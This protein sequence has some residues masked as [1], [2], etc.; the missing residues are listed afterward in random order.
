MPETH[1]IRV[2]CVGSEN[3]MTHLLHVMLDNA[4]MLDDSEDTPSTRESYEAQVHELAKSEGGCEDGFLYECITKSA[5]GTAMT[6]TTMLT[7]RRESCGLWTACF[8]YESI[9]NF[10]VEDWLR[11]HQRCNR[12]LMAAQYASYSFGLE[13]GSVLLCGGRAMDSWDTMAEVWL[14]LIAKYECGYPPEEAIQRL[15]K[16]QS[17]L[18]MEDFGMTIDE[19]LESCINVL[20]ETADAV[21]DPAALTDAMRT[22]IANRDFQHLLSCQV[23]VAESVLWQVEH[24]HKWLANLEAIRAAW[25]E[26][27]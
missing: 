8:D 21:A 10:Q 9:D 11:L 17:T 12:M 22:A 16:L 5:F 1:H 19:L 24:N 6:D 4:G 20:T 23:A 26:A 27:Q 2:C 13:K 7:I 14:W 18:D 3:D 25:Q 15:K